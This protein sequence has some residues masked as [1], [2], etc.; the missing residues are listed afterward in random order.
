M[1]AKKPRN[2]TKA[3]SSTHEHEIRVSSSLPTSAP[4]SQQTKPKTPTTKLPAPPL[5]QTKSW[6]SLQ[7][8]LGKTVFFKETADYIFLATLEHT[9]LGDYLYLPYGPYLKVAQKPKNA[10][11]LENSTENTKNDENSATKAQS[12]K[13]SQ[14]AQSVEN[15]PKTAQSPAQPALKNAAR[16]AYEALEALGKE[17]SATFIR[18]EP[19][20]PEIADFWANLPNS[21]KSQDLNPAETWCL[22]LTQSKEDILHDMSQGTRTRHNTFAKKGLKVEISKNPDDIRHL[23]R[24]QGA[25]AK[26][27]GIGTFS[28]EYL[29]TELSQPFASLF[30]VKYV[31]KESE[32][33]PKHGEVIAASLFFDQSSP[34]APTKNGTTHSDAPA[35]TRYYMQSAASLKY[36]KL[37]ATV[38][39]L[40][41]TIFDAKEKGLA[42]FDFW[43]IA[44]DGAP[45]TH[46]WY[47][48]TKFK[49]S[50][51]GYEKKYC[52]TF[53]LVLN[54]RRYNLYKLARTM[55]RRLRKLLR[56]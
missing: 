21:H 9:K 6:Q 38:A 4:P 52:G 15:P 47:G 45:K 22:D 24:L 29:K 39:L 23:V 19:Q 50:F 7:E 36:K 14:K 37:P 3:T 41:T 18:I 12:P 31:G 46:P 54:R 51:G 33:T 5:Q 2:P 32:E 28:E 17:K 16:R 35:G 53:D 42:T 43:G 34:D 20:Q 40:S 10:Q 13:N 56:K 30:L 44:P 1:G 11:N 27:R 49:Q 25:L 48:F 8:S 55:N 26:E